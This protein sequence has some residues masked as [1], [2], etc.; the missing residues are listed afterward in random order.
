[1]PSSLLLSDT[2]RVEVKLLRLTLRLALKAHQILTLRIIVIILLSLFHRSTLSWLPHVI[3]I[4]F[5]LFALPLL[6]LPRV[7]P[8]DPLIANPVSLLIPS[9]AQ[10]VFLLLGLCLEAHALSHIRIIRSTDT[11]S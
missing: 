7:I 10:V 6:T 1:M 5:L 4:L 8:V 9:I 3:N 11:L 2:H